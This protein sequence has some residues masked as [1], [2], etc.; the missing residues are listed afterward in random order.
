MKRTTVLFTL[1]A[2]YGAAGVRLTLGSTERQFD[3]L[4]APSRVV[5]LAI[6]ER[7][8]EDAL[9]VARDLQ[10][11]HPGEPLTA[12]WLATIFHG[13]ERPREELASWQTYIRLSSAPA[14]AC[15]A[16]A[17]AAER[18][19][20]HT[21]SLVYY[22]NCVTFEPNEPDRL[23]DLGEAWERDHNLEEAA[24]AYHAAARLDPHN[25][26]LA[27]R[28]VQLSLRGNRDH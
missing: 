27:R 23:V 28:I 1:L 25:G 6:G 24:S 9:P 11:A 4:S 7:R 10:R 14:E 3:P 16:I 18:A 20:E 13:L 26:A 22:Q 21:R 19:G 8:F 2:L 15:P 17:E 12:F 5:E